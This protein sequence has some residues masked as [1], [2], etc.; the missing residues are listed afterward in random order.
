MPRGKPRALI[1]A[2]PVASGLLDNTAG[3]L[4]FWSF[5][6]T[7]GAATAEI[8]L[9][10]GSSAGGAS[11]ADITL[12]AGQSTRDWL[13]HDGLPYETGLFLQVVSGTV[14]GQVFSI[15]ENEWRGR[16]I[17]V[18]VVNLLDLEGATL[19]VGLMG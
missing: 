14:N 8:R 7:T 1:G 18:E 2:L 19:N 16:G 6:E 13:G 11:I 17:P 15:P 3:R 12:A 10:D 4:T 9:F 5:T